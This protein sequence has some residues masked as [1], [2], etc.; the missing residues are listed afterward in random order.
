MKRWHFKHYTAEQC[1]DFEVFLQYDLL[2]L[3]LLLLLAGLCR[4][5]GQC[6]SAGCRAAA[7]ALCWRQHPGQPR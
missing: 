1:I 5:I 4:A 3:L 6:S 2:L 7:A